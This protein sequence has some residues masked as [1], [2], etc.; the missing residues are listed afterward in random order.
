MSSCKE[1]YKQKESCNKA[2]ICENK[3]LIGSYKYGIKGRMIAALTRLILLRASTLHWMMH[4]GGLEDA[5]RLEGK[6]YRT[7]PSHCDLGKTTSGV[8]NRLI[9]YLRALER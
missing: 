5:S 2:R 6:V 7:I 4:G 3:Y 9:L 1:T 8:T